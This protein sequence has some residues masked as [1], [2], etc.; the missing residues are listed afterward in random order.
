MV[1]SL[2]DWDRR[3]GS[4]AN[5]KQDNEDQGRESLMPWVTKM[6]KTYS[7]YTELISSKP[8]TD[9]FTFGEIIFA[10]PVLG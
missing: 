2:G 3:E 9:H 8:E 5:F 7:S 4:V 6:L 10:V 1:R